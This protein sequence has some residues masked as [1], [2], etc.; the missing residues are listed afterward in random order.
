MQ[1]VR[2]LLQNPTPDCPEGHTDSP[3]KI[4]AARG[5]Q[6]ASRGDRAEVWVVPDGRGQ[7]LLH[8]LPTAGRADGSQQ[9]TFARFQAQSNTNIDN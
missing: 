2:G 3:G 5:G 1:N 4:E 8:G 9:G 7:H 6:N